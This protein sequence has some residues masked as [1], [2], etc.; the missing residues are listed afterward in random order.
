[1]PSEMWITGSVS[2]SF[3]GAKDRKLYRLVQRVPT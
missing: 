1:M 3:L 2:I